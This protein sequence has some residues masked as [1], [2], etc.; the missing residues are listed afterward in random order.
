MK[1]ILTISFFI[2]IIGCNKNIDEPEVIDTPYDIVYPIFNGVFSC[3]DD[4]TITILKLKA[5]LVEKYNIDFC[6]GM[7]P[8]DDFIIFGS[9]KE[10]YLEYPNI[11]EYVK[12]RFSISDTSNVA[13]KMRQLC[14]IN[15]TETTYGYLFDFTDGK[16]CSVTS[17]EGIMYYEENEII[18]Y[19]T[20]IESKS[21][22]C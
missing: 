4:E 3:N 20:F 8:G 19:L 12:T 6:V 22:P 14:A 13:Y 9:Y 17:Y 21:V 5:Y 1:T 2:L 18:E 7:P 11:A 15:I 10:S 16:C